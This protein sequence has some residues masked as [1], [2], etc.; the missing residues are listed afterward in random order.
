MRLG[1]AGTSAGS[2][3]PSLPTGNLA[4]EHAAVDSH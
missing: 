1:A 4:G 2:L 3:D